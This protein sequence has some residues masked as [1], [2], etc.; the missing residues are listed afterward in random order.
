MTDTQA[1]CRSV[2]D[3]ENIKICEHPAFS[4]IEPLQMN[5]AG[6]VSYHNQRSPICDVPFQLHPSLDAPLQA[7]AICNNTSLDHQSFDWSKFSYSFMSERICLQE[8][9]SDEMANID[10]FLLPHADAFSIN[11]STEINFMQF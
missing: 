7:H 9:S 5:P 6:T 4:N 8:M 11:R 10:E 2:L 3:G 1:A